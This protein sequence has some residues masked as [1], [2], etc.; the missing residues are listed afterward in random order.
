MT[1]TC[2][3]ESE[4][5]WGRGAVQYICTYESP[6]H[7]RYFPC[8]FEGRDPTELVRAGRH[9]DCG[10]GRNVDAASD[11]ADVIS[12]IKSSHCIEMK[13]LYVDFSGHSADPVGWWVVHH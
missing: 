6:L 2:C 8:E 7:R 9:R 12:S 4:R 11:N 10:V 1:G 5:V 3:D 13:G